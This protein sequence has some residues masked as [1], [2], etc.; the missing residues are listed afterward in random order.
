MS[1]NDPWLNTFLDP[2]ENRRCLTFHITSWAV[3]ATLEIEVKSNSKLEPAIHIPV[4]ESV[5][6]H[7]SVTLD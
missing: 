5:A 1:S 4:G 7:M 6:I 2:V 3:S